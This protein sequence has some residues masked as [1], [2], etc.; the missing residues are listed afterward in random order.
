LAAVDAE[1]WRADLALK[2]APRGR[3][4]KREGS[5]VQIPR[6]SAKTLLVIRAPIKW[7][8]ALANGAK[9]SILAL[10]GQSS[11]TGHGLAALKKEHQQK[12]IMGLEKTPHR[13]KERFYH[14]SFSRKKDRFFLLHL[15]WFIM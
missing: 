10:E 6:P 2:V 7:A 3:P 1:E 13:R 4:E 5:Q 15:I 11:F 8:P 9:H 12:Q 14:F